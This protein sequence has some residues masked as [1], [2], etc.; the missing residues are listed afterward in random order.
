MRAASASLSTGTPSSLAYIMR[1]RSSGRGRLP[2]WVVR[3]RS[4]LRRM[5]LPWIFPLAGRIRTQGLIPRLPLVERLPDASLDILLGRVRIE[6]FAV[7]PVFRHR[8]RVGQ[9]RGLGE[10]LPF[11]PHREEIPR[12]LP[13]DVKRDESAGSAAD[14][15]RARPEGI[16]L[17]QVRR[18]LL[19]QARVEPQGPQ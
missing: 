15:K 13:E 12:H 7:D 16:A 1:T 5:H 10:P 3:K 9:A 19:A 6:L 17:R 11:G 4:V 2:V 14:N 18:C 8:V